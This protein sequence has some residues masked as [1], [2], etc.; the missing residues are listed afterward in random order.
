MK[1][2]WGRLLLGAAALGLLL[3]VALRDRA[4]VQ[5]LLQVLRGARPAWVALAVALQ[6][7]TLLNQPA[8]Y[9][10]LYQALRLPARWRDL[11]PLVWAGHFL[12]AATPSAGLGGTALLLDDARRR[13]WDMA[14]ASLA[15][16]LYFVLNFAV[17]GLVL[18]AAVAAL[19]AR[20]ELSRAEAVAATILGLGLAVAALLLTL[21]ALRPTLFESW[22]LGLC[23]RAN[24]L[25]RRVLKRPIAEPS[26]ASRFVREFADG[27][28]EIGRARGILWRIIG[29]AL[30][31]DGLE[32]AVL[33][34]CFM[35]L[36]GA[37]GQSVDAATVL[38]GYAIGTLF[39]VV[40]VTPQ[41]LGV[42]EGAMAAAFTSMGVPAARAAAVVLAYR[43][44]SFWLPLLAGFL[45]LRW[46]PRLQNT[47]NHKEENR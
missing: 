39:L 13:G 30:L 4:Q 28:S 3:V 18:A 37:A 15:S 32:M 29:H 26:E 42:V 41:G 16:T 33:G 46:T 40:S 25:A 22:A 9:Q 21:L 36:G 31:V 1:S 20:H 44:L 17:F 27:L 23:E 45:A 5:A 7:A 47:P 14:R 12:N 34:T 43:G 19:L 24:R 10:A 6:A 35:A 2:R 11:A 8:L 38:T